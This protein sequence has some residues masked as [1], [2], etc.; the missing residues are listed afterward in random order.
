MPTVT[1]DPEFESFLIGLIMK[2]Y[3]SRES[4]VGGKWHVSDL[5]FP[6]Y[7]VLQRISPRKPTREDVG[8]FLTGE[9]Y[10]EFM[11]RLLGQADSEVRGE[12]LNV[13][14]TA[15]YFNG[16]TLLE[17]KTSRK[18]TVPELP[19]DHYIEQAG[20]YCVIFS[21][22]SARIAV[23]FPTAGR[24]WDGSSSSTIEIVAH[25]VVFTDEEIEQ[26]KQ[27]MQ[28][29]VEVLNNALETQNT[30][31]LSFC[32]DW[33]CGSVE[34]DVEKQEYYI[35]LRCPYA[36]DKS[37]SGNPKLEETCQYKNDHRRAQK[38]TKTTTRKSRYS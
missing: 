8:F 21:K 23:I 31:G 25:N 36:Q 14:G 6:R 35:K 29:D 33:K 2:N 19:Q 10:H 34:R 3:E 38:E 32:P 13:L 12:L 4:R 30:T 7:A 11:Q 18:W 28:S 15:D 20:Y 5:M 27:D 22:T 37:C 9:A 16:D 26:I 24:K 17:I 1:K